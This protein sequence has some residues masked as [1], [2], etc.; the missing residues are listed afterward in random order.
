MTHR[1][2]ESEDGGGIRSFTDGGSILSGSNQP[3][4]GD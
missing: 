2:Q 3:P 1:K 4:D